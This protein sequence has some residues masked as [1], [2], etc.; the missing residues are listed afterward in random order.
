MSRAHGGGGFGISTQSA[1]SVETIHTAIDAV[2]V[3]YTVLYLLPLDSNRQRS[4]ETF[5]SEVWSSGDSLLC[6]SLQPTHGFSALLQQDSDNTH[7]QRK[8]P[9]DR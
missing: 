4:F 5:G 6:V 2:H 1:L 3:Q 7:V 9:D 8:P